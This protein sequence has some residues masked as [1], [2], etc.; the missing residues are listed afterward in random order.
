MYISYVHVLSLSV[1]LRHKDSALPSDRP[2]ESSLGCFR[3]GDLFTRRAFVS[4]LS[5]NPARKYQTPNLAAGLENPL[6]KRTILI[7]HFFTPFL[8][9]YKL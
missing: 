1:S 9:D 6:L 8:S 2:N 7:R 5:A 3:D 4:G